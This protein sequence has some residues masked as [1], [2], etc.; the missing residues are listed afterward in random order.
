MGNVMYHI[1]YKDVENCD[2]C[3]HVFD[4]FVDAPVFYTE[5]EAVDY[6]DAHKEEFDGCKIQIKKTRSSV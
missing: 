4:D 6:V 2:P 5:K 1:Y 3:W